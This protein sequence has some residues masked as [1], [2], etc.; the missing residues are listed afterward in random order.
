MSMNF[1]SGNR[2]VLVVRILPWTI[3]FC[4]VHLFRVLRSWTC[5]VQMK[6]GMA[7]IRGNRCKESEQ[8]NFKS[9]EV[10]RLK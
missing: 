1:I 6:S 7:F 9:S 5:S 2:R 10:K 8:D 4:I 3:F